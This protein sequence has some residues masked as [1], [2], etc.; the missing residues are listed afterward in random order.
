MG[1]N[2]NITSTIE[3]LLKGGKN[4]KRA[5]DLLRSTNKVTA[6]QSKQDQINNTGT[7]KLEKSVDRLQQKEKKA[8]GG[9]KKTANMSD[10][11]Q[12]KAHN[13]GITQKGLGMS[14]D[15]LNLYMDKG[16]KIRDIGTGQLIKEN[17]AQRALTMSSKR[18]RMEMLSVMFFGMAIQRMFLGLI[19]TSL[20][21]AG[22][23]DILTSAL[24]LLF[25]P[26][27]LKINE[28]AMKFLNWVGKLTEKQKLWIGKIAL[29]GAV[30]GSLLMV[31]GMV[32]L[33][34]DGMI[35]ITGKA[36]FVWGK[37]LGAVAKVG[38]WKAILTI[39]SKIVG[40][41]VILY[42]AFRIFSGW[43]EGDWWKIVSGVLLAVGGIIALVLGG[44]IPA[45]IMAAITALVWLG[46]KFKWVRVVIISTLM[47]ALAPIFFVIESIK[48]LIGWIDQLKGGQGYNFGTFTKGTF[49]KWAKL[50]GGGIVTGPTPAII[51]EKGPEAV[52]PL[53]GEGG[54]ISF[55][56]IINIDAN[57]S[58]DVD[59]DHLA[60]RVSEVMYS[61][62][63][64][65]GIR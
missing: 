50:G 31:F 61:D 8:L 41:L 28:W 3:F 59:I 21:W 19:K 6:L 40:G 42:G 54:G 10:L 5:N 60:S 20:G 62:L 1:T 46:D 18:F 29:A 64:R 2:T 15:R 25:L 55:S 17:R 32:N 30:L 33:G 24:G 56:P 35:A 51:G 58:S 57:V 52:I 65:L 22:T 26:I 9:K 48:S 13:L 11:M 37:W 53:S 45:A 16:G 27:A 23:M 43:L 36:I 44:W 63:R 49:G 12:R 39:F 34:I 4:A 14:M 38:A 47:G 7:S